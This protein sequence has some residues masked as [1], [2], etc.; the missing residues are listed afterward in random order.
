MIKIFIDTNIFLDLFLERG[1]FADSADIILSWC[2]KGF[3]S[4]FTS[5]INIVNIF[6]ILRRQK[7][8]DEA[9]RLV[10]ELLGFI[11]IYGTSKSDLSL[12]IESNF[13][14]IEDAIQ[15]YTALNTGEVNFI[16]TRNTKDFKNSVIPFLSPED[17]ITKFS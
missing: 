7:S 2:E 10:R 15:Y 12:A 14:D 5:S 4:G 16:V 8:K 1:K 6:Y 3:V 13:S 9:K 17:F 11:G